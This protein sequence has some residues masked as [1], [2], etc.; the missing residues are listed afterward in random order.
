[1][2]SQSKHKAKPVVAEP[3]A[4]KAIKAHSKVKAKPM[5]AEPMAKKAIKAQSKVKSQPVITEPPA[6]KVIKKAPTVKAKPP[7]AKKA[8]KRSS[9]ELEEGGGEVKK[10]KNEKDAGKGYLLLVPDFR[11]MA[12][13]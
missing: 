2:P 8:V 7:T 13:I 6:K 3:I 4:K 10:Q 5:E 12:P 9:V 1:M 11:G